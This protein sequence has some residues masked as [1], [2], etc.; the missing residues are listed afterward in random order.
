LNNQ[1]SA[2]L[3]YESTVNGKHFDGKQFLRWQN[4]RTWISQNSANRQLQHRTAQIGL[5]YYLG[6]TPRAFVLR[7]VGMK[8]YQNKIYVSKRAFYAYNPVASIDIHNSDEKPLYVEIFAETSNGM[9]RFQSGSFRLESNE[10]KSVPVYLYLNEEDLSEDMQAVQLSIHCEVE[11]EKL[12][13][14]VVPVTMYDAHSWDGNTWGLQQFIIPA[15][16]QIQ[17]YSKKLFLSGTVNDSRL[18]PIQQKFALFKNYLNALGSGIRYVNDP[19]T[20]L[21]VDRVQFPVETRQ[22]RSGDCEDLTVYIAAHVMALGFG[23]AVVD[24]RPTNDLGINLPAA[25][26]GSVGHVFLLIDT[27]IPVEFQDEVNLTEFQS[28]SRQNALGRM[29]LWVPIETTLIGDGLDQ[30][31]LQ[32]SRLYYEEVMVKKGVTGGSVHV[33]DFK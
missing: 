24:I 30:A 20:T 28:V 27:G 11:G 33:Y 9:G 13:L 16:P 4:S 25:A 18:T 2:H 26:P 29:T 17:D 21:Y 6:K 10:I 3:G 1:I 14:A 19:T 22:T 15:D 32:G 8:V 7:N 31:M 12:S 23:C 5:H